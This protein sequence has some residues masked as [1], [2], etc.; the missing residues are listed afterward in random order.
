MKP[1]GSRE[2]ADQGLLHGTCIAVNGLGALF[3]GPSGS[4]KSDLALRLIEAGDELVADDQV[5]LVRRDGGLWAKAPANLRGLIEVRGI[6]ILRMPYRPEA[7]IGAVFDLV[8]CSDVPRLPEHQ[9]TCI[10][11]SQLPSFRIA[12]L[13][14]SALAKVH[15]AMN[16]LVDLVRTEAPV[17]DASHA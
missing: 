5:V 1:P 2:R 8:P 17:S 15:L 9:T 16:P 12:A 7:R 4:G 6:G 10:R 13:Q 11:G 3:R 14:A